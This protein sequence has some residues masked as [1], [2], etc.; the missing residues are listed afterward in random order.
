MGKSLAGL[1]V[2]LGVWNTIGSGGIL[3]TDLHCVLDIFHRTV[4]GYSVLVARLFGNSLEPRPGEPVWDIPYYPGFR[5]P[6]ISDYLGARSRTDGDG[7]DEV[8]SRYRREC[9]CTCRF[10]VRIQEWVIH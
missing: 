10:D 2:M 7:I 1:V 9:S 3:W 6:F 8:F 5:Q 4:D